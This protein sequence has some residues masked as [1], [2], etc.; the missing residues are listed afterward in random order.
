[1]LLS[2]PRSPNSNV[3]N[4]GERDK[5]ILVDC[6]F[7]KEKRTKEGK[8]TLSDSSGTIVASLGGSTPKRNTLPKR[9]RVLAV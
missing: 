8:T 1:M 7:A 4:V 5:R 2:I 6:T 9:G 3:N